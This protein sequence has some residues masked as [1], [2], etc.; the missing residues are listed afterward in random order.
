MIKMEK[1]E[2]AWIE[3]RYG[4]HMYA[5]KKG[6]VNYKTTLKFC[7]WN[8]ILGFYCLGIWELTGLHF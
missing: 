1:K 4:R 2:T 8:K 5:E 7:N 6:E 3:M